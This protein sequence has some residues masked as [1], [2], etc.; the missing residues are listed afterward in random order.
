MNI[1]ML[2]AATDK[3]EVYCCMCAFVGFQ[4]GPTLD[5]LQAYT[6]EAEGFQ[7]SKSCRQQPIYK[8]QFL[9]QITNVIIIVYVMI[10]Q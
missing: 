4:H 9:R 7:L 8:R 10:V 3:V 2:A 5:V 6:P 1:E